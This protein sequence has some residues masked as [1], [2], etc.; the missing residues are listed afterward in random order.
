LLD[1]GFVIVIIVGYWEGA[2]VIFQRLNVF[3]AMLLPVPGLGVITDQVV[4]DRILGSGWI[5]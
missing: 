4:Q 3:R 1:D 2:L 5:G